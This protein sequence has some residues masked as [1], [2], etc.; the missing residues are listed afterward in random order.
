MIAVC[1]KCGAVYDF[2]GELPMALKCTCNC[3]QF[4]VIEEMTY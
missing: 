1:E 2:K 4:K 3:K